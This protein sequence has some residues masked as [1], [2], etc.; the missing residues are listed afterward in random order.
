[1][2]KGF[3]DA[4]AMARCAGVDE[5]TARAVLERLV[6]DGLA[7]ERTGRIQG[8]T[9][10][11]DGKDAHREL[12]A[13]DPLRQRRDELVEWYAAFEKVNEQL[14]EV[15]T[16]WQ[17]VD[18]PAGP[19]PNDHSDAEYDA[20]VVDRLRGV[21]DEVVLLL[22]EAGDQRLERYA[23]RLGEAM[24]AVAAGDVSRLTTPLNESYHDIWM[25]LHHDLLA[26]FDRQRT[27]A[28]A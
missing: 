8:F 5:E 10:T 14:K 20:A 11:P 18:G 15:C 17:L 24:D 3:A 26:S 12:I 28:D 16:A 7:V 2:V 6:R 13:N 22:A 25:E 19:A 21:H 1:M 9:L 4:A 23:R 27:A